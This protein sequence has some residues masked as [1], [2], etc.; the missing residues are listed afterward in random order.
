MATVR[1]Y[2]GDNA[3]ERWRH[4]DDTTA[5]VRYDYRIVAPF[6]CPR[7]CFRAVGAEDWFPAV[8]AYLSTCGQL[9]LKWENSPHAKHGPG[10]VGVAALPVTCP[11]RPR[12][13]RP[14]VPEQ[15]LYPRPNDEVPHALF[16]EKFSLRTYGRCDDVIL[17]RDEE[18]FRF[19]ALFSALYIFDSSSLSLA[20]GLRLYWRT[21]SHPPEDG[22]AILMQLFQE[23]SD[24]IWEVI[25]VVTEEV[26]DVI[27][28]V[29][30][31]V[32]EEVTDVIWEVIW[33]VIEKV[34]EKVTE[35]VI[36][37]VTEEVIW[38]VTE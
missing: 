32:T 38:E 6:H 5:T 24:V 1:Q 13:R 31:E 8:N 19:K 28:E 12:K 35:E 30:E 17:S 29:I 2:D 36:E 16:E 15:G 4:C 22:S 21:V 18:R 23:V 27:W 9:R 37:E 3:I 10:A 26:T 14:L 11:Y 20:I 7:Y 25:E 33:E 34:T